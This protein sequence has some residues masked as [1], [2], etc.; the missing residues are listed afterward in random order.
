MI[1]LCTECHAFA[2]Q[3]KYAPDQLR[4]LKLTPN[5]SLRKF[6]WQRN[7]LV[8]FAGGFYVNPRIYLRL[9]GKNV[10]WFNRDTDGNLLL[11]VDIR[12][13]N[14]NPVIQIDD[15]DLKEHDALEEIDDIEIMPHGQKLTLKASTLGVHFSISFANHDQDSLKKLGRQWNMRLDR[16]I[17]PQG[18]VG[19]FGDL[20]PEQLERI[21]ARYSDG[22]E[23]D[24]ILFQVWINRLIKQGLTRWEDMVRFIGHWPVTVCTMTAE[25]K[26]P[27][28]VSIHPGGE[29]VGGWS[30]GHTIGVGSNIVWDIE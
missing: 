16:R 2:D 28:E 7:E 27:F 12:D 18:P 1:A 30:A 19:P 23:R 25:L 20:S 5:P 29:N 13:E 15:N 11:N 22:P 21:L 26:Y 3:G 8:V 10:V 24:I 17:G 4:Y 9:R 14:G 6:G